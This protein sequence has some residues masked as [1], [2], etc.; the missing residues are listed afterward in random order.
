MSTPKQARITLTD[1]DMPDDPPQALA[2]KAKIRAAWDR[3]MAAR[4]AERQATK[5]GSD[6]RRELAVMAFGLKIG[7]TYSYRNEKGLQI[8]ILE[9]NDDFHLF[10]LKLLNTKTRLPGK[11]K[12]IVRHMDGLELVEPKAS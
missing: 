2:I 4:E 5:E 8:G 1:V 9:P 6:L 10:A 3:Q 7:A 11:V 12:L